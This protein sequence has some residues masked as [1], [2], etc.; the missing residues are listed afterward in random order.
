MYVCASLYAR[1]EI[2]VKWSTHI[3]FL[4]FQIA[5]LILCYS[6]SPELCLIYFLAIPS[7]KDLANRRYNVIIVI[8]VLHSLSSCFKAV[9]KGAPSH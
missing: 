3:A 5:F 6:M 4:P 2:N 7:D 1:D 8:L 9:D